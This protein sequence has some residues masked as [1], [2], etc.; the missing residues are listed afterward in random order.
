MPELPEVETI[1]NALSRN[2]LHRAFSNIEIF[3][4]I[5]RYPLKPLLDPALLNQEI[6]DV[7]RR[8]RYLIIELENQMALTIHFGMSGS[9]RIAPS[10]APRKKHEHVVFY[11]NNGA[12]MRF[13]CPRRFGFIRAGRLRAPGEVPD[14][15]KNLGIEPLSDEFSGSYLKKKFAERS[16]KVKNAIMDNQIVV[17]VGNIYANE[18]LFLSGIHP[19]TPVGKLSLG[20]CNRLVNHIKETL[21]KAIAAG[22]TTI[23]DFKGVDGSEGKFV[24]QLQVYGKSTEPCPVCGT[25]I[26]RETIGG[27]SSFYCC[28]CQKLKK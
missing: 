15:L 23:A 9:M 8:A 2:I 21:K 5:C 3:I 28:K 7:R 24:Q 13:D 19:L 10:E 22:G 1:K 4:E 18:S 17:G 27:R 16:A 6:V 26:S 12:T 11:L 14:E 25:A 20:D